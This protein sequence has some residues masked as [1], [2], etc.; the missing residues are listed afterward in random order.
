MRSPERYDYLNSEPSLPGQKNLELSGIRTPP[1][2]SFVT[3]IGEKTSKKEREIVFF[4]E[5]GRHAE[6]ECCEQLLDQLLRV[7]KKLG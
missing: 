5:L 4:I 2:Q 3:E 6:G 1:E 7:P